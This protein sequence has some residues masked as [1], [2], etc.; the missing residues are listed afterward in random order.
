MVRQ[1]NND[2]D[3]TFRTAFEHVGEMTEAMRQRDEEIRLEVEAEEQVARRDEEVRRIREEGWTSR[4]IP[5][6]RNYGDVSGFDRQQLS[7]RISEIYQEGNDNDNSV[8]G[9][10]RCC[11]RG[12][13]FPAMDLLHRCTK[14]KRFIHMICA[15]PFNNLAE[16][17]RYCN[18]CVPKATNV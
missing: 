4:P 9:V 15:E 5:A 17:E 16:D 7:E 10:G 14:C 3:E 11:I 1:G 2:G 8:R 12:C 6:I 13:A 18:E